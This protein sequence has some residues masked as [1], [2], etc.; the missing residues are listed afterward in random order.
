MFALLRSHNNGG[1]V[2]MGEQDISALKTA[3]W[4]VCNVATSPEGAAVLERENILPAVVGMAERSAYFSLRGTAIY[5]LSLVA[6]TRLGTRM[7]T[8]VGWCSLRFCRGDK[9]PVLEEWFANQLVTVRMEYE[10]MAAANAALY[11]EDYPVSSPL[12][13]DEDDE[14]DTGIGVVGETDRSLS[15]SYSPGVTTGTVSSAPAGARYH[16]RN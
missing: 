3:M 2:V 1:A 9:W 11:D 8:Q 16:R 13:L 15:F 5:A 4:A 7:L 12:E 6:T 14:I 10:Q